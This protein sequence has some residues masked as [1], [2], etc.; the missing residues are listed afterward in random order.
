M[1]PEMIRALR[2]NPRLRK[3]L[4][5]R[6]EALL[7]AIEGGQADLIRLAAEGWAEVEKEAARDIDQKTAEP[8]LHR[9]TFPVSESHF[10]DFCSIALEHKLTADEV[11]RRYCISGHMFSSLFWRNTRE[12]GNPAF[13]GKLRGGLTV[14]QLVLPNFSDR[15]SL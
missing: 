2:L 15:P 7:A 9:V 4:R 14:A 1:T 5:E 11:A 3:R 8:P 6:R 10:E 13:F 12:G